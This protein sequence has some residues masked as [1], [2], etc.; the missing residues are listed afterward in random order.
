MARHSRASTTPRRPAFRTAEAET[1]FF[2]AY[3]SV[4]A[5]WPLAHETVDLPSAYGTTRVTAC[6]SAD[7]PP[8]VLLH[9][10]GATGTVWFDN[11]ADLGRTHRVYA[12]DQIGDAG[13]SVH[14]GRPLRGV[15]DLMDW[16]DTVLDGLGLRAAA[17]VG[18]SYGAWL[19]LSYALHAPGRVRRLVLLDPT[20]C[21]VGMSLTYRLRAVPLLL[22]PSAERARAFL[23]WETGG[24]ALDPAW[25]HL[26]S[27][28]SEVRGSPLVLPRRPSA[29]RLGACRV[30]T[31][32]V[33][34]GRSRALDA[35]RSATAAGRLMPDVTNTLLPEATHHTLPTR[36]AAELD[37]RVLSFLS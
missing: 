25:L 11:V 7:A 37:R 13:R 9:G 2:T 8:L 31:L 16:L 21:F 26:F 15:T 4:L 32:Q 33:L 20:G 29:A 19:A 36:D 30:P 6:G 35:E 14:D 27:L 22:R 24:A 28:A 12:V 18:H 34:A 17:V 23:S 1:E 10:G 5:R 3:D